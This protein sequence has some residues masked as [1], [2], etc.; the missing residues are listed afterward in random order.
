MKTRTLTGKFTKELKQATKHQ[1]FN[2]KAYN[3]CLDRICSGQ[4]LDPKYKDHKLA[5]HSPGDLGN[6][7]EFHLAPDLCIIYKITDDEVIF[8]RIGS[9]SKIGMTESL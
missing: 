2:Q 9:H 1:K 6:C 3:D 7:R 5:K 4:P 8:Y